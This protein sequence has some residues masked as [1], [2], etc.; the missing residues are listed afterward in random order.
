MMKIKFQLNQM[1]IQLHSIKINKNKFFL[2]LIDN[3]N[4]ISLIDTKSKINKFI[5]DKIIQKKFK[6]LIIV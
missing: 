6:K 3:N 1:M 5:N 2:T 4:I